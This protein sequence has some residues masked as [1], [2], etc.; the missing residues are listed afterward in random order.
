MSVK[1][2]DQTYDVFQVPVWNIWVDDNF[3]CRHNITRESVEELMQSIEQEGLSY[4]IDVQPIEDVTVDHPDGFEFRLICGFRRLTAVKRLGWET[5][6]AW[7][8]SGLT[9]RQAS[10][11]NFRENLERKDLNILEEAMAIDR[12]FSVYRSIR[13]IAQEL[14]K[15]QKWVSVRRNL[16]LMSDFIKGLAASGRLTYRDLQT[17]MN[18]HHPDDKAKEILLA[19]KEGRKSRVLYNNKQVRTKTVVKDKIAELLKEGFHPQLLRLM[20]WSVGEVSDAGLEE[21]LSWLRDR[22]GWLK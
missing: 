2:A 20:G 11:M 14:K 6:P 12:N 22:K 16:M 17:V 8:R 10:M 19:A 18:A 7:I 4:P 5:V 15:D 21:A 9:E 1:L 13:S 3:N